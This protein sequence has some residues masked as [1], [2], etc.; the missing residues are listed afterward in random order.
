[1]DSED[2]PFGTPK[3]K[4]P[5]VLQALPSSPRFEYHSKTEMES[6][7][8]VW[9]DGLGAGSALDI[10]FAA[11]M[12]RFADLTSGKLERWALFA[13]SG[14]ATYFYNALNKVLQGCYNVSLKSHTVLYCEKD[15]AKISHLQTQFGPRCVV[16]DVSE[17]TAHTAFN[18]SSN[19]PELLP[20][21]FLLDGGFPCTSRTPLSSKRKGNLNCV[22]E[23]RG[24]TGVG[25]KEI[26]CVIQKHTPEII[27]LECVKELTQKDEDESVS[28][29]EFIVS[30]LEEM[31]YWVHTDIL[32]A[33]RYG[34]Y[35]SRV[36][37][38]WVGI[39]IRG[40][41]NA[42][43]HFFNKILVSF[44]RPP[45]A[46]LSCF[47]QLNNHIRQENTE[48]VRLPMMG[49]LGIRESREKQEDWK[50]EHKELFEGIGLAWP[51]D[52]AP[53]S[54]PEGDVWIFG[55]MYPREVDA[56]ILFH[57]AWA[58]PE[59]RVIEFIDINQSTKRILDKHMTPEGI[60]DKDKTA[61]LDKLPTLTGSSKILMRHRW[62]QPSH[63]HGLQLRMLEA[64]EY[65]QLIG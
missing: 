65:A 24:A 12:R 4:R 7:I 34:S 61:W 9:L 30:Q 32:D 5:R 38:Y 1:M 39:L 6:V 26:K 27:I 20:Y 21:V 36:R 22:Q 58:M 31:G 53:E 63:D 60:I 48:G 16:Q 13:G 62:P 23:E 52:P 57:R 51:V 46:P 64:Y 14:V 47:F 8:C 59:A 54:N 55:G 18:I 49:D 56:A 43:T 42:I 28:D 37:S 29:S 33:K 17:L 44:G 10:E 45:C 41:K 50:V 40:D 2:D 35:V 3:G 19:K 15:P 25:F 11:C